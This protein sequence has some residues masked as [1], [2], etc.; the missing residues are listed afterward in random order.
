MRR[1]TFF[2]LSLSLLLLFLT[3]G[4]ED[5]RPFWRSNPFLWKVLLKVSVFC[6]EP[7][8]D[9]VIEDSDPSHNLDGVW[10]SNDDESKNSVNFSLTV[11][12]FYFVKVSSW[13]RNFFFVEEEENFVDESLIEVPK[14]TFRFLVENKKFVCEDR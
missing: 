4:E 7:D 11:R 12:E 8:S 3:Q 6:C 10:A 9:Y 2:P 1:A 14:V 13:S 5:E